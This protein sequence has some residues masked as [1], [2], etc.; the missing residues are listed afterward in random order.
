M[1]CSGG[2]YGV[3]QGIDNL[4]CSDSASLRFKAENNA[5]THDVVEHRADIVRVDVVPAIEPGVG[6]TA[7]VQSQCGSGTSA[8]VQSFGQV[9]AVGP[10]VA[11]REDQLH[12]VLLHRFSHM[13]LH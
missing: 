6:P 7:P 13:Q 1:T 9:V 12:Q 3:E 2:G 4:V 8:E 10:G 5:V 11:G